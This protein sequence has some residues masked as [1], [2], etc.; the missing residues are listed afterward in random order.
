MTR[1]PI[2]GFDAQDFP[3]IEQA[4][5]D[6][7]GLLAAGGDLSPERLLAAYSRGIFPWYEKGQPILWWSP[8]PRAVL[9]PDK[10]HVSKSLH[11]CLRKSR[12]EVTMDRA[13]SSVIQRCSQPRSYSSG[14]WI[15]TEMRDAYIKLHQL[16]FAHSVETWLEGELVGGLYGVAL[17]QLFFGESMFSTTSNA[18][19]V[20]FVHL[21]GQLNAWGFPLI[22]CQLENP[23]LTSLGS[24]N[25]PRSRFKKYL[26]DY[27]HSEAL[28]SAEPQPYWTLNWQYCTE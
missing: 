28:D 17:G 23:H 25:I 22:D 26:L 20:A 11:K 21:A 13:F 2:L 6:P 1:I 4:L 5:H 12:F 7:D 3:P 8:N 9:F 27:G 14:T 15:T 18:S 24:E 16:G 19:K 10:V